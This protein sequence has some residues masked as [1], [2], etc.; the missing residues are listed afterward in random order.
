MRQILSLV[1][2]AGGPVAA[3]GRPADLMRLLTEL[4]ALP[5]EQRAAIAALLIPRRAAAAVVA[6]RRRPG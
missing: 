5:P 4:A 6:L 3:T 1:D 2:A